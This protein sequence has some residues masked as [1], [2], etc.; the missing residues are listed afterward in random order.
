MAENVEVGTIG[1]IDI[2]VDDA[3]G[4][5]DFYASVVG[6]Q[7]EDVPMGDYNDFSMNL[8]NS[9]TPMAGVCHARGSNADLPSGWMIYI[10][11]ADIEDSAAR[12]TEQ[13]GTLLVAP[14][15]MGD[16]RFCVIE[17]PAGAVAALYQPG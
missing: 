4:L 6:W 10:T 7:P 8:P 9:G 12:C 16:A 3:S 2:T 1:W 5:R 15:S 14:K 11:V 13:G 17:D